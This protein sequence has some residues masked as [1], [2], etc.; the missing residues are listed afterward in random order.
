M[1][2]RLGELLVREKLITPEQ[3]KKAIEEQRTTGG[4]L[5]YNLAKLG[6]IKEKDLTTFLSRQYGIPAVDLATTEIDPEVIKLIPEDVANKYQV[7]PISRTGSTLVLAMADPS[8]IFAIDDIKFLT[9]YNIESV[10][11]SEASIKAAI[12][13]Y[14][15]ASEMELG[16]VL[17]ELGEEDMEILHEE[18]EVDVADLKKAVD[19]APV[20]KLVNL[21]LTDAIKKGASDIHVEPYE[22]SFRVRFRV[23]GVLQEMMKPPLKLKNAIVSRL[24]IMASLDIAERRLPQDGR[25]K[26]KLGRD[27]EMDFRVSVLPTLFGEKVVLRLLDKSSLQL[28]MTKLGFEERA[29]KDFKEAIEKP[30]G[31]VLV[32]GPTGSGKTTTL[33]SALSELNKTTD[34]ISTAEDP[35]EY[36]LMGI[37]QVQMH[38]AIGLNFAS[39]LRSFLRQDPD[40]IMVGEI[41]DFE[42]AEIAVKAALTGHLVL[43]TLHTNDAPST[44]NRLLN[45]GIEP[46]LI[47][48]ATN[49]ILAQRL[50][51]KICKDCKEEVHVP[52]QGLIDIGVPAD[53]AKSFKCYHGKGCSTCNGSGYKGR[54]ALYEVM[55]LTESLKELVLNGASSAELKRGAV[56][57]G[58]KTL[59]M[60][61]ITKIKEGVTTIEEVVRT[62]MAD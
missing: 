60:S 43:S 25:I 57:E 19:D 23:D 17:T 20:V 36:N 26:M 56:K 45:M 18:E 29:L 11:A 35:V 49:L 54:I 27:K 7:I 50:A 55:P 46:F 5:G 2:D 51:R 38:E 14:Y 32:T 28:D 30:W 42:T 15:Q 33:Y 1:V 24:K 6:Y 10:V 13:K 52:P 21:I 34:N 53:D 9:G 41:R 61:G 39:A 40:I 47:A 31:M 8:N 62:T 16:D 48:S 44:V 22:K 59:R 4:R 58:M 3:L 37:N 12:E